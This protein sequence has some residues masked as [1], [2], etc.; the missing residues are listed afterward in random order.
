MSKWPAQG[1]RR[2]RAY[3][4]ALGG[5][6]VFKICPLCG[7]RRLETTVCEETVACLLRR[8][9]KE[10]KVRGLVRAGAAGPVLRRAFG[11]GFLVKGPGGTKTFWISISTIPEQHMTWVEFERRRRERDGSTKGAFSY[12]VPVDVSWAP[13]AAVKVVR[14]LEG[15]K[16]SSE[17]RVWAVRLL[18]RGALD[19]AAALEDDALDA[20]GL[21]MSDPSCRSWRPIDREGEKAKKEMIAAR[22]KRLFKQ[23]EEE[24]DRP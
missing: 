12:T 13:K 24:I 20:V 8:T 5:A 14:A 23:H 2:K 18:L 6:R 15:V 10:M 9:E 16:I 7:R 11:E 17:V 3:G 21:L 22:L 19:V 1:P 4:R